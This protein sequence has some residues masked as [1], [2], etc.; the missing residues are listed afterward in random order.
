M[1]MAGEGLQ[2]SDT[3]ATMDC[4][5]TEVRTDSPL[6]L[7]EAAA[8]AALR[9]GYSIDDL[10]PWLMRAIDTV[11]DGRLD[12]ACRCGQRPRSGASQRA[13]RRD[14]LRRAVQNVGE[15]HQEDSSR[16]HAVAFRLRARATVGMD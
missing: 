8:V 2:R 5:D 7:F 14:G 16:L 11:A 4:G 12:P 9:A 1:D 13:L 10:T 15:R 3:E 6:E